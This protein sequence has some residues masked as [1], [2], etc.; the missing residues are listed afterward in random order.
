M[1]EVEGVVGFGPGSAVVGF[2]PGSSAVGF[3]PAVDDDGAEAAHPVARSSPSE[4]ATDTGRGRRCS[5]RRTDEDGIALVCPSVAVVV[6]IVAGV[7]GALCVV[8]VL[9]AVIR[10][11][12]LPRGARVRLMRYVARVSRAIFGLF[13]RPDAPFE[14]RDRVLAL[15]APVTLL[16]FPVVALAGVLVGFAGLFV[17]ATGASVGEC[18]RWS[19]SSLFTLG[20]AVPR[21]AVATTFVFVEAAIGLAL[22]AVLIAYLPSIYAGFSRRESAVT[23]LAVRAG[24]PPSAV[25]LLVV[26]YQAEFVHHLDRLFE[27]WESWFVDVEESH[28]TFTSLIFFR[29]PNPYRSWITTAGALLDTAALSLSVLDQPFSPPAALCLRSGYLS[30][31]AVAAC[32]GVEFDPNPAA[33]DPIALTRADFDAACARLAE[34]GL[35]LVA[36]RDAAWRAFAGWRVNY[37]AVLLAIADRLVTPPAPWSTDLLSR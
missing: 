36:D 3:G 37:D 2:G 15:F 17:A 27:Q 7:L 13:A 20:V 29:S 23:H 14:R 22:L 35:P 12:V 33:D 8:S 31:R 4:T 25:Q 9:D 6:R 18:L 1:R 16:A 11:F 19:G 10:T 28:S 30:L 32:I 34:A 24:T 26:A 21:G 5:V